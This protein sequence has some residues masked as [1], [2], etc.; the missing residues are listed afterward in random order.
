VGLLVNG[1]S[2]PLA[3]DRDAARFT[4]RSADVG[5]GERQMAYQVLVASSP[6]RRAT[7]TGDRWDSG[8]VDSARS[9]SVEY[10]GKVL[11]SAT[12]IWWTVRVWDQTAKPSPYSTPAYF[13]TGLA[14]NEWTAH[15]VWDGITNANNFA[16]FRKAF[17]ITRKPDLAKVYVTA[18]NDYLLYF[19]RQALGRG[20]ARC[21]P[22]HNGQYNA[23]DINGLVKPGSNVF[24]AMGHWQGNWNDSG[25]DARP[26][27]RL[28]A[29]LDYPD[30][31]S[32]RI[33]TDESWNVLAYAAFG[34]GIRKCPYSQ[35]RLS[36]L[37]PGTA[38]RPHLAQT[39]K[40]PS[41]TARSVA[42]SWLKC[43]HIPVALL[44]PPATQREEGP[45]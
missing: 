1:V 11:P 31:S 25:S 13:D 14:Q 45:L 22:Y 9:A 3:I 15:C 4:L 39:Q 23:Y 10:A 2:N 37:L 38:V 34:A 24:A 32:S 33:A 30:G 16:H 36:G 41:K 27:Y 8:K 17:A 20:P 7:R 44:S 43:H 21:D 6:E 40:E 19:N 28:E 12:R 35:R 5:R 42:N 18:H 26:A 29:R